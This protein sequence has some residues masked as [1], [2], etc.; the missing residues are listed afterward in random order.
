MQNA[1][2][3]VARINLA[4]FIDRHFDGS[5]TEY[6]D[7]LATIVDRSFFTESK[8]F[9]E[10]FTRNRH[11][12]DIWA[13]PFA[14]ATTHASANLL[15]C[16]HEFYGGAGVLDG[17][18]NGSAVLHTKGPATGLA[19]CS[20]IGAGGAGSVD[21]INA[22][23]DWKLVHESGHFLFGLA[24][25]YG[26]G[27]QV[28]VSEPPNVFSSLGDCETAAPL[29]GASKPDCKKFGTVTETYRIETDEPETMKKQ[30]YTSDF[31]NSSDAAFSNR[32][33]KCANGECYETP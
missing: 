5:L 33:S 4:I 19:D 1:S 10:K 29:V 8:I 22:K 21:V 13:F 3:D 9:A 30:L 23:S 24:D 28:V 6:G 31:R 7:N 12:F 18:V 14:S 11:F 27:G 16:K 26:T 15:T 2:L 32:I 25:E 20:S 17:Q